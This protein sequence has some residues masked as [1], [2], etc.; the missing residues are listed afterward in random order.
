MIDKDA[1]IGLIRVRNI[2]NCLR[3]SR[4]LLRI[5]VIAISILKT[6]T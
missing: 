4:P 3:K 6:H 5:F 1:L 2:L